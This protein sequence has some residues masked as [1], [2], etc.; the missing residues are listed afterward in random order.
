[1]EII[2]L[3]ILAVWFTV[4]AIFGVI[5]CVKYNQICKKFDAWIEDFNTNRKWACYETQLPNNTIDKQS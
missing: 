2:T 5:D 1:M 3:I 4:T